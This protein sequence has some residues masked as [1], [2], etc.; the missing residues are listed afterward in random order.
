MADKHKLP[1]LINV[2]VAEQ[3]NDEEELGDDEFEDALEAEVEINNLPTVTSDE[4]HG[5]HELHPNSL[6][7]LQERAEFIQK[8]GLDLAQDDEEEEEEEE[9][10]EGE[11]EEQ[12]EASSP[13][14][15]LSPAAAAAAS[16]G[17]A[18]QLESSSSSKKKKKKSAGIKLD[19]KKIKQILDA[20]SESTLDRDMQ[21]V[22]GALE[23]FL[24]SKFNQAEEL[25]SKNKDFSLYHSVG[26]GVIRLLKAIFTFVSNTPTHPPTPPVRFIFLKMTSFM[27]ISLYIIINFVGS[28]GYQD[29]KNWTVN[30]CRNRQCFAKTLHL[31]Y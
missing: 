11:E 5:Q 18:Q 21:E 8:S 6:K 1:P 12:E 16:T 27:I 30:V 3:G 28:R 31:Y 2:L 24:D 7:A 29:S 10:D 23:L 13:D 17:A 15:P 25:L 26:F 19:K 9:E 4:G 20:A 22:E 14:S